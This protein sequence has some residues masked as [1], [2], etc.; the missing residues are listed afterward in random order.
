[1]GFADGP[2]D[3]WLRQRGVALPPVIVPDYAGRP[4]LYV[5]DL[6]DS[7][8]LLPGLVETC[9]REVKDRPR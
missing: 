3:R 7:T 8:D 6:G 9:A 5:W 4:V 2:C 1:V